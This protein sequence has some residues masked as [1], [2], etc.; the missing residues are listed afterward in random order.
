MSGPVELPDRKIWAVVAESDH[1]V[2]ATLELRDRSCTPAVWQATFFIFFA[3]TMNTPSRII[4]EMIRKGSLL[5][6][7]GLYRERDQS[8]S[9]ISR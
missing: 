4:R 3:R 9:P 1:R 5:P 6:P 2:M 8:T 7:C